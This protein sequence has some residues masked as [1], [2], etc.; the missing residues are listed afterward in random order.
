[1]LKETPTSII[2]EPF[3]LIFHIA[4]HP[5]DKRLVFNNSYKYNRKDPCV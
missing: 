4:S 1:V 2:I 3:L 5:F